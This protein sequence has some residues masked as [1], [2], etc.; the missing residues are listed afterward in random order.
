MLD[1]KFNWKCCIV[2]MLKMLWKCCIDNPEIAMSNSECLHHI[3]ST[4]SNSQ[5]C[6]KVA[7]TLNSKFTSEGIMNVVMAMSTQ[8]CNCTIKFTTFSGGRYYGVAPTLC[9]LSKECGLWRLFLVS[10]QSKTSVTLP[11]NYEKV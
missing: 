8:F 9:Q 11:Q 10:W 2:K 5:H 4:M 6:T 3:N 7:S 1:S